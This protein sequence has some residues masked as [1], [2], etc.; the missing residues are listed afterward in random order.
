MPATISAV[1]ST[2]AFL[3]GTAAVVTTTSDSASTRA[4]ISRCRR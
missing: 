2:G 4:I 3:P 1:N